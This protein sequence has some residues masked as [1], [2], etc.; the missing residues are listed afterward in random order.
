M[1]I[2][3]IGL[4]D[5]LGISE[6]VAASFSRD[7]LG[8]MPPTGVRSTSEMWE[9][10]STNF[11]PALTEG[12]LLADRQPQAD[13]LLSEL[14]GGP[15]SSRWQADSSQEVIAFALAAIRKAEPEVQKFI[16]A[17]TLVV[18]TT[19]AARQLTQKKGMIFLV[20]TGALNSAGPLAQ[21]NKVIVPIGRDNPE[22]PGATLLERPTTEALAEA[23]QTMGLNEEQAQSLARN[24]GRS[25]TILAR[26]IAS[27]SAQKPAWAGQRQLLPALLAGGW[28]TRSEQDRQALA[29]LSGAKD[30]QEYES[31]LLPFLRSDDPPLDREGDVWK[32]R[33]PVDAFTYLGHLIG[34]KELSR[35][36]STVKIVFGET[37]PSL[38]LPDKERLYAGIYGKN[39]KYSNWLRTGLATTLR[40]M[41]VLGLTNPADQP[42][43]FVAELVASLPGLETDYRRIASLQDVLPILMEAAPRPLLAALERMLEGGGK[44]FAPIF[45]DKDPFLSRSPHTGLLWGLEALAWDPHYLNDSALVL[46]KLAR[47][48]PGGKLTNRPLNSL[49]EIFLSWHPSTNANLIQRMA[50]L[51]QVCRREPEVG[52]QLIVKLLPGLHEIASPTA[53]PRYLEAGASGRELLTYALVDEGRRQIVERAFKVAGDVPERWSTIVGELSAFESPQ[54]IKAAELLQ[55][56]AERLDDDQ[57][58]IIWSSLREVVARHKTFPSAVWAMRSADIVPL[59]ELVVKLQPADPIKRIVWLF[60]EYHPAIPEP[61]TP[62]FDRVDRAREEATRDLLKVAGTE[63][64]LKLA[65]SATHPEF[66]ALSSSSVLRTVEDFA[67]LIHL[68]MNKTDNLAMFA[69][70]LSS[71]AERK[72]GTDWHSQMLLWRSERRWTHKQLADLVLNWKDERTTW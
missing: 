39:L 9:E 34:G 21:R 61:E 37:D 36:A 49:R 60:S 10:Y 70:A 44:V 22:E 38:E 7:V 63:G 26:R 25:V 20:K 41:A 42:G 66:V 72:I 62:T 52:W 31:E 16:E 50:A 29:E 15:S 57:R 4:E 56:V 71:Q 30:Y 59:E 23:I 33:A 27:T 45:Q 69:S 43:R 58:T 24:C 55:G 3:A 8:I 19:E 2:D 40:I 54:R 68:A 18:E 48:D 13:Q 32:V 28:N 12:V 1:V 51:D 65:D 67:T 17:R 64:L 53:K 5:W 46:A 14:R 6:A 35:L 47:I 11:Q